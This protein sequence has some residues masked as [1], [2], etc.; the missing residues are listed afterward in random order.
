MSSTNSSND[1]QMDEAP[2]A[3]YIYAG[4]IIGIVCLIIQ[5]IKQ[6]ILLKIGLVGV[7]T[8]GLGIYTVKRC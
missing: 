5:L 2:S 1:T 3:D 7:I 6:L 8:N 4:C